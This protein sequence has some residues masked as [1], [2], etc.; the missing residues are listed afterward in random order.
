[1]FWLALF[2][3]NNLALFDEGAPVVNA[4]IWRNRNNRHQ[5]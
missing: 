3:P 1:M 2:P 5:S 4:R